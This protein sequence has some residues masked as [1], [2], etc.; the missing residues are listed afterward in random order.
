MFNCIYQKENQWS[1][2]IRPGP[3]YL[4]PMAKGKYIAICEGDDYWTDSLKLQKQVDFLESNL[5]YGLVHTDCDE[6]HQDTGKL[7]NNCNFKGNDLN[8]PFKIYFLIVSVSR[9]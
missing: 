9:L 8:D 7:I 4:W 2:G 1:K 6:L 3:S 5:E